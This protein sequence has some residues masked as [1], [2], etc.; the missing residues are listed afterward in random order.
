MK[1]GKFLAALFAVIALVSLAYAAATKFT[2]VTVTGDLAV[3]GTSTTTGA[4]T[5]ALVTVN[6]LRL[7]E[8]VN[9]SVATPTVAG[10]IVRDSTYQVYIASGTASPSQWVKIGTQS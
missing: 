7:A 2:N 1:S 5:M 6:R 9:V 10:Q 3:E 4:S 8:S